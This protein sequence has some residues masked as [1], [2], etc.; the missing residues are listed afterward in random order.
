MEVVMRPCTVLVVLALAS[1][2]PPPPATPEAAEHA[3]EAPPGDE[4]TSD[5][6]EDPGPAPGTETGSGVTDVSVS[7]SVDDGAPSPEPEEVELELSMRRFVRWGYGCGGQCASSTEGSS[8][9]TLLCLKDGS[10]RITDAGERT[11][12]MSYPDGS[13]SEKTAWSRVWSGGYERQGNALVLDV[14]RTTDVCVRVSQ[15]A[16]GEKVEEECEE[17]PSRM[18]LGCRL[19][20]VEVA[21][22]DGNGEGETVDAWVCNP[23]PEDLALGGT[24]TPWVF[25]HSTCVDTWHVGEPAPETHLEPC[26]ASP[27]P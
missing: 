1:C 25:G 27:Q 19:E 5:P 21:A 3:A 16:G 4:R 22:G 2:R 10:A 18:L 11:H 12:V 20:E 8:A 13:S 17:G 14:E 23:D 7:V 6:G 26:G 24:P 9:L 15:V